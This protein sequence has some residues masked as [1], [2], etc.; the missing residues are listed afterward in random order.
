MVKDGTLPRLPRIEQLVR[1]LR[2]V[3]TK[4]IRDCHL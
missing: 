4:R 1:F 2:L 3:N